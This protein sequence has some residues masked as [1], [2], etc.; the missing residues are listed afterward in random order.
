MSLNSEQAARAIAAAVA[1]AEEIKS[2]S[3]IAVLDAGRNLLAYHRMDGAVLASIEL[4][5]GKAYTAASL[6]MDS[7]DLMQYVQPG[8]P[9]YGLESTHQHRIVVF[10]GGLPIRVGD[11]LIGAI[12]V[13]GGTTDQDILIAKAAIDA[14]LK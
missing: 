13:A 12:G 4:S 14:A 11:K 9:F 1:K 3:S 10:A 7:G 8:A 2:P 6:N 5:Q